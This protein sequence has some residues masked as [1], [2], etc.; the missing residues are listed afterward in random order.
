MTDKIQIISIPCFKGTEFFK[1]YLSKFME[2][3]YNFFAC[4]DY[5][6]VKAGILGYPPA[7]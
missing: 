5:I 6:V 1:F 7:K 3:M 4:I 2:Y